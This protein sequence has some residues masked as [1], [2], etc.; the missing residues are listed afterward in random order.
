MK[1]IDILHIKLTRKY[2]WYAKWHTKHRSNLIHWTMFLASCVILAGLGTASF[3]FN[4]PSNPIPEIYIPAKVLA[5]ATP[6]PTPITEEKITTVEVQAGDSLW[7]IAETNLGDGSKYTEIIELN[8]DKYPSLVD[9]PDALTIGWQLIVKKETIT[10]P[11]TPAISTGGAIT[12]ATPQVITGGT[13]TKP[14]GFFDVFN[15]FA[16]VLLGLIIVGLMIRYLVW[17]F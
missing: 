7:S 6:I 9:N 3:A 5:T 2:N 8:K 11:V 13:I 10:T 14:L 15:V 12:V 4:Q 1:I 16:L 17:R